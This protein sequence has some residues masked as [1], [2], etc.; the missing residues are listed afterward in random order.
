MP[1]GWHLSI[2]AKGCNENVADPHFIKIFGEVLIKAVKMEKH[3]E[4]Q[5]E[6]FGKDH[7]KGWTYS[8]LITTSNC[9]CHFCDNGEMYFDLFSCKEIDVAIVKSLITDFFSPTT[10]ETRFWERG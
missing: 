5:L 9:C 8:Q 4:C 2:D 6:Y 1:W 10:M 7:L 3:G